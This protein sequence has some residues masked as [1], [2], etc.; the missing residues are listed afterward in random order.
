MKT[1]RVIALLAVLF[2]LSFGLVYLLLPPDNQI[3]KPPVEDGLDAS[4]RPLKWAQPI[5]LPGVLNLH[6]VSDDLY[7][8]A[9]PT[10]EGMKNLKELGIRSIVNLRS[11]HSDRDEIGDLDLRYFHIYMKAWHGEDEDII[12]FLKIMNAPENHPVFIHCQ[13]GADRTGTIAAIYRI[14][15]QGW[16][17]EE[18]IKEMVEGGF[19]FHDIWQNL[20]RYLEKADIEELKRE[21]GISETNGD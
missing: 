9:Q 1:S 11:F 12:E 4:G 5:D 18:A 21:A 6:K 20:L 2:A 10:A 13:H 14:V 15:F 19:G 7:R 3:E 17:K 16:S 8:G